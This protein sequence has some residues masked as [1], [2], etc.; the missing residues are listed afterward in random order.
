MLSSLPVPSPAEGSAAFAEAT[1]R[2][3]AI[4]ASPQAKAAAMRYWVRVAL[5][6][7]VLS[8]I[9]LFS[10]FACRAKRPH[11]PVRR[12]RPGMLIPRL[13][14]RSVVVEHGDA[15]RRGGEVQRALLRH[16]FEKSSNGLL[17]CRIVPRRQWIRRLC[18]NNPRE[19]T[20]GANQ[21]QDCQLGFVASSFPSIVVF[22]SRSLHFSPQLDQHLVTRPDG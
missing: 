15:L 3:T 19:K 1:E 17:R 13:R 16:T 11:Q 12:V 22:I 10:N 21:C 2:K 8:R 4:A 14:E 18:G 6:Q 5:I 7:T 20:G 9:R